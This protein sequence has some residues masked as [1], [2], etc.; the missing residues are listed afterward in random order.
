MK[1]RLCDG[2][3]VRTDENG[4]VYDD[5][6]AWCEGTGNDPFPDVETVNVV[7]EVTPK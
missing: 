7:Y 1:C 4:I 6:C 3:G 2:T 5:S